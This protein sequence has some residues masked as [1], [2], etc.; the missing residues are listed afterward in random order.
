MIPDAHGTER[1]R[2]HGVSRRGPAF[3]ALGPAAHRLALQKTSGKKVRTR[4]TSFLHEHIKRETLE[5]GFETNSQ[6]SSGVNN[7]DF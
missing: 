1:T 5:V 4:S 2:P 6:P 7:D 3:P